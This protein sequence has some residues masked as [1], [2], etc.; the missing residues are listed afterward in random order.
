[1]PYMCV[2][3]VCIYMYVHLYV[4]IHIYIYICLSYRYIGKTIENEL[5]KMNGKWKGCFM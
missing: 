2:C 3:H 5:H 4:C 1:M